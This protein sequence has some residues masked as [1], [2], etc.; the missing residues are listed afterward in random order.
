V[1]GDQA[2]NLVNTG[3]HLPLWLGTVDFDA[4]IDAVRQL[5]L[6]DDA[7]VLMGGSKNA[8][9]VRQLNRSMLINDSGLLLHYSRYILVLEIEIQRGPCGKYGQIQHKV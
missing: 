8:V 9:Q 2:W 1:T 4:E 6:I 5:K 3:R 7:G